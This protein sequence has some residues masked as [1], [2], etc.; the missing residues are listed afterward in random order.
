MCQDNN[1]NK[2]FI[3]KNIWQIIRYIKN[4]TVLEQRV[5][6]HAESYQEFD[7]QRKHFGRDKL[8]L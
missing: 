7:R 3:E 1:I 5:E 6:F 2:I 8:K 4:N